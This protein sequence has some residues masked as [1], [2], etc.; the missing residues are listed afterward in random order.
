DLM[1]HNTGLSIGDSRIVHGIRLNFRD[2]RMREV[3]GINA[4]IWTP[5][6]GAYGGDVKG[7]ALGLPL[8]GARNISGFGIGIL[9]A[10]ATGDFTGIGGGLV[11]VGAGRN[12]KGLFIG[13]IGAGTG[14]D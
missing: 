1:H 2:D 7:L 9:G 13:G 10:G 14:G 5:Y 4:T 6:Q 8:T 12:L 3:V 11:G